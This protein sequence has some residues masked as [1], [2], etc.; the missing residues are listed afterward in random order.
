VTAALDIC[1]NLRVFEMAQRAAGR[2]GIPAKILVAAQQAS[3]RRVASQGSPNGGMTP[4]GK[5]VV[6]VGFPGARPYG[7]GPGSPPSNPEQWGQELDALIG[8]FIFEAI[9]DAQSGRTVGGPVLTVH[10]DFVSAFNLLDLTRP[11]DPQLSVA[12]DQAI[13]RLSTVAN[14]A[15]EMLPGLGDTNRWNGVQIQIDEYRRY[16]KPKIDEVADDW[17][18]DLFWQGMRDLRTLDGRSRAYS[19]ELIRSAR[20]LV[21]PRPIL[22]E[23]D[24]A[25]SSTAGVR[26]GALS[27][28]AWRSANNYGEDDAPTPEEQAMLLAAFGQAP[29]SPASAAGDVNRTVGSAPFQADVRTGPQAALQAPGY[30]SRNGTR[31]AATAAPS[32]VSGATLATQL[33]QVETDARTRLEEA[34]EAA[35]DQAIARAGAK[36][37]SYANGN[38]DV[39]ATLLAVD[40]RDVPAV[41]G[42]DRARRLVADTFASE[43]QRRE[44]LFAAV[45][46]TLLLSYHRVTQ[47]AYARALKLLGVKVL[48]AGEVAP[49]GVD[50]IPAA[51]VAANIDRGGIVLRESMLALADREVFDPVT[52]PAVGELSSFRVPSSVVRRTLAAAGGA[53]VQ[54]GLEPLLSE[55]GGLTFGPT[56]AKYEPKVLEW[57]WVYGDAPRRQPY[58]PHAELDG[59][60]FDGP[61]DPALAGVAPDGGQGGPGDHSGCLCDWRPQFADTE[62]G[63]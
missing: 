25:E 57:E 33:A 41:L 37:K 32:G 44:D 50:G 19:E 21:D 18:V 30:L 26:L 12:L 1:R 7:G 60:V 6:P 59:E 28:A 52:A 5:V 17:T 40:A 34:C 22:A 54:P 53:D 39:R 38:R 61:D 27:L 23:P 63:G 14:A 4:D 49:A 62:A 15:P 47:T 36:L 45:L 10:K 46:V 2:S 58:E 13:K 48:A 55:P 8:D 20:I 35:L 16:F 11:I 56:L 3:P 9:S 24:R 43:A 29:P 31:Q 42:A 51:E